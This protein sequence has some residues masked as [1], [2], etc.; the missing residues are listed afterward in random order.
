MQLCYG[1]SPDNKSNFSKNDYYKKSKNQKKIALVLGISGLAAFAT[2]TVLYLSE[3]GN[4]LPGGTGYNDHVSRT[5]ETLMYVGGG[6]VLAC[7]PFDLA[8][9]RN[10]KIAA[11]IS[12]DNKRFDRW[13]RTMRHN[14][15]HALSFKIDLDGLY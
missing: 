15:Y 4:G 11:S 3:F 7:M 5:G 6:L 14:S 10:K 13:Q 12:F 2:G 1:Q 9:R 8:S